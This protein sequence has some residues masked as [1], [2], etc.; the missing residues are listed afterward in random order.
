VPLEPELLAAGAALG[1]ELL[2]LLA[3]LELDERRSLDRESV[4]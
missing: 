1:D 2:D 4:R 3:P